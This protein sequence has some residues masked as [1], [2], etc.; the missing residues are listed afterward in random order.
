MFFWFCFVQ[1]TFTL[2]PFKLV[3]FT[4]V[5]LEGVFTSFSTVAFPLTTTAMLADE[6]SLPSEVVA[7]LIDVTPDLLAVTRPFAS[8]EAI[9]GSA[10]V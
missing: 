9:V 3:T 6:P 8:T 10:D 4:P 5:T 7:T 1:V 2:P